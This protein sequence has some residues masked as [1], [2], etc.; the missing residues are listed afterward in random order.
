[1][2]LGGGTSQYIW[3]DNLLQI[4]MLPCLF[5]GIVSISSTRLEWPSQLLA[6][7][8]LLLIF[9][10]FLP[11]IRESPTPELLPTTSG[12]AFYSLSPSNS[13]EAGLFGI[14]ILGFALFVSRLSDLAQERL[15]RF[16]FLGL[17]LNALIGI[18]QLSFERREVI[19][20]L[21]PFNMNVGV[22]ANENHYS[23]L[24]F[25][26][27][28]LL[29]YLALVRWKKPLSYLLFS[30]LLVFILFAVGSR[31]GMFISSGLAVF[32]FVWF[33]LNLSS[34]IARLG[35]IGA[36]AFAL[37]MI[38]TFFPLDEILA[39]DLRSVIFANTMRAIS[40][41][42]LAG[43][44]LGSFVLI[45]PSYEAREQVLQTYI[46]HAH[47]DYMELVLET[48]IFGIVLIVGYY[49][50]I[51]RNF[52]HSR[53]AEAAFI[54]IMA[55]SLHSLVDYPL[56]TMAIAVPFALLSAIILST[57]PHILDQRREMERQEAQRQ[58]ESG[59]SA[60]YGTLEAEQFFD[61]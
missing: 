18:I 43:T 58:F 21:L 31:A 60:E 12:W 1:M 10:Q 17:F 52:M 56:R 5:L 29:A 15:L 41:N 49:A 48:G 26:T 55:V 59:S 45:Y 4:L 7:G 9:L 38:V 50:V 6:V 23:T 46:N 30:S 11:V 40:D 53:L 32:C 36:A 8:I 2:I 33:S 24:F 27:I 19:T 3:T 16:L 39:G 44:G 61:R 34:R 35:L 54:S 14:S 20:D 57:K 13:L 22:F 51:L 47:N 37:I 42:W 28:P 25:L